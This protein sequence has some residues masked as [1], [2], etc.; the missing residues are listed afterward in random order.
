MA[1]NNISNLLLSLSIILLTTANPLDFT[2]R[3][4]QLP[5]ADPLNLACDKCID[6]SGDITFLWANG[7]CNTLP[8]GK[9]YYACGKPYRCGICMLFKG[10]QCKYK[11]SCCDFG[12]LA[13]IRGG[14][15]VWAI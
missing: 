5:P 9:K 2:S 11:N 6:H 7:Q 12:I 3:S 8:D 14:G 4:P 15:K 13:N 1:F 10:E